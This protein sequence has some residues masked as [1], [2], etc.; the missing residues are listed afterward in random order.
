M[1]PFYDH[2]KLHRRHAAE[3][4]AAIHRVTRSGRF[5]WGDE[6]PAF[7]EA[8][9][10]FNGARH[11]VATGSGTSALKCA[12]LALRVGPGDEVITVPNTDIACSSAI[13]F[14]G[15]SI[16]WVDIDPSTSTMDVAAF[17]AAI[18]PRTR[19]VMPVDLYGHP[20]DMPAIVRI[21]R[22]HKIAI[23][24]D[25]CLAL[26][27]TIGGRRVGTFADVTCFSF[28]PTKHLG[29]YGGGG[30]CLTQDG[31][32]AERLRMI[33]GYGQARSRHR[34]DE[35]MPSPG[36]HHLTDGLNERLHEMQAAILLAKLPYLEET[37]IQRTAQ[38]RRYAELLANA[39]FDLPR[40]APGTGHAWRNYVVETD[41]RDAVR[42]HLARCGIET[43]LSYAPPMHL[44]PVYAA[45]G[46]RR[47][48]FPAAERSGDRLVGLPIGP[49]LEW[50]QLEQVA[51]VLLEARDSSPSLHRATIPTV[52]PKPQDRSSP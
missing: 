2:A 30:A 29:S 9:A 24:E 4:D 1:V 38:A 50:D 17:E 41:N 16:V 23:V 18:T 33:S 15:A 3:I 31:D 14:C 47:G 20:A 13:R 5:D 39:A 51:Q 52:A 6:V 27:A 21:A 44:Q 36:L 7:E 32:L 37:L 35:G 22:Q 45:L 46:H 28:A 12:L 10:A 26:G 42:V 40:E 43:A 11:A 49:H 25:A 19:A 8:F 48:S 34:A